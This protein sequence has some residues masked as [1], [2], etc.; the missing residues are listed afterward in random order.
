MQIVKYFPYVICIV[1][2]HVAF[3]QPKHS[4]FNLHPPLS[5]KLYISGSFGE[6]RSNSFH[7]G[8]DFRTGGQVGSKVFSSENGFVSRI[9]VSPVGFGKAVY[10]QHPNG[11][12]TVYAHLDRFVKHIDEYVKE[13]QYRQKSFEVDL[14]L[15]PNDFPVKRGD[16][17]AISGNSGSSGGPHLHY[18]VRSTENQTP[19]NPSFSNLPIVDT[20]PPVIKSAWIY[21]L[22][23]TSQINSVNKKLEL[24]VQGNYK[25]FRVKDTVRVNGKIGV[26]VETFDYLSGESLRCGVYSIAMFVNNKL[27]YKFQIDEFNF[28]ETRYSNSHIDFEEQQLSKKRIHRLFLDPNNRFSAYKNV[29]NRGI[30][31]IKKDTLYSIKIQVGDAYGKNSELQLFM[32]GTDIEISQKNIEY[33]ND[34]VIKPYWLFYMDNFFENDFFW[35]RV[36]KNSLYNN[37]SF[38]YQISDSIPYSIS[39]V[40]QVHNRFTPIHRPYTLAVKVDSLS[41]NYRSKALLAAINPDG[42]FEAVDANYV[43]GFIQGTVNF[44]G[45]FVAVVDT[46][47]PAITPL[48]ITNGKNM[49]KESSIR[50]KVDDQLSGILQITGLINDEW[51]LFEYDPKNY[52]ISYEFDSKRLRR[53][54]NH[55]LFL[56]V[57]DKKGN[58]QEFSCSFIW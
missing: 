55:N 35:V 3:S 17:I 27:I 44:F 51:A 28:F 26:G 31:D 49:S 37:L 15:K 46:I 9:R 5:S 23:S 45:D 38:T 10:I 22:D 50:L 56:T 12:T 47:P 57:E 36:P 16:F 18:E 41:N 20:I 42:K 33:P 25:R 40:I 24:F 53:N 29:I 52:L 4:P 54:S 19:L 11:L 6:V 30:I 48:N 14:Y 8:L 13:H 58:K 43:N 2:S 1:L 32:M 34:S 7:A 21:P 39:P